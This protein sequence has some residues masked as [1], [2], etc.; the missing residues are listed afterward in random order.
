MIPVLQGTPVP[1]HSALR[2]PCSHRSVVEGIEASLGQ[3]LV[4]QTPSLRA[5]V[6]GL[7]Q[8]TAHDVTVLLTGETGTGK[9]FLARLIH[10][11]STRR[12]AR[13]LTVPCGALSAPLIDSELFGH[14]RGAFT[15]AATTKDGKF[16][17]A[18]DG[19]VLLDEIDALDLHQQAKLLRVVETGEYERVGSNETQVCAARMV[20]ASNWDLE[21][22]VGAGKFRHDLYYRL[23]VVSFHLPP[24]R[25]RVSDVGPL[26]RGMV[27]RFAQKFGK[28]LA[29][30]EPGALR[31]L[32]N[33]LWPGNIRQLENAVQH[34]VL[35]SSGPAL[36]SE[37]LPLP[38]REYAAP[39]AAPA[40]VD[41]SLQRNRD[42]SERAVVREALKKHHHCRA[43]AARELGISRVDL[44]N[45]IKRYGL[46]EEV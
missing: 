34:A 45:K 4:E 35:M 5:L 38:V 3:R 41:A 23:N 14:V 12:H 20:V 43:R 28:D 7:A 31:L 44:H 29:E 39:G 32:E 25:E 15:G 46:Q 40:S 8:V 16:A 37:H 33:Y 17:A 13:F 10:E 9:S 6:T 18:A 21:A 11:H 26:V 1:K 19:T 24:L 2:A 42:E 30:V 27:C 36:Q 22:A